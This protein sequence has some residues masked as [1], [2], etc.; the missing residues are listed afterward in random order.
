MRRPT[1]EEMRTRE[2]VATADGLAG[3]AWGFALCELCWEH[4]TFLLKFENNEIFN[5]LIKFLFSNHLMHNFISKIV[6]S[7]EMTKT[8]LA[9]K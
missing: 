2:K 8:V 4:R 7:T 6:K 9:Y 1:G 3:G 5:F